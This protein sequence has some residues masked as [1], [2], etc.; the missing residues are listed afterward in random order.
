LSK[1]V[2]ALALAGAASARIVGLAAPKVIVANETFTVTLLTENYIQSVK[3]L[4]AAFALTPRADA[5]GYIGTEYLGSFYLGPDKSNVLTNITFEVTAPA[6]NI[7]NY[8]NGVVTSLY[9]VSNGATTIQWTV[10]V[11]YGDEVSSEQV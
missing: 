11:T 5:D 8:L 4:V 2:P 3:D 9:G 10:P 6:T 7:G 1:V